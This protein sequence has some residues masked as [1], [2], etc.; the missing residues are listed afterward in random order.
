MLV[1]TLNRPEVRNALNTQM[2]RSCAISSSA[3]VHARGLCAASSSPARET[4][5]LLG[6]DLKERKE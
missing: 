1:V 4:S 3:E 5:L 6:G 2:G